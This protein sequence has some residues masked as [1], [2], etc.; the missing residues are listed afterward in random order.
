MKKRF[1]SLWFRHLKTDWMAVGHPQLRG[2]PF[3]LAISTHGKLIVNASN[4][5]AE[6]EGIYP[7]LAIADAK[8]FLPSLK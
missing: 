1:A 2:I 4:H 7:G 5:L 6:Q 8:A 3:V